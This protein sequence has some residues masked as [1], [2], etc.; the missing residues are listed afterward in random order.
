MKHLLYVCIIIIGIGLINVGCKKG[1]SATDLSEES[2]QT[3]RITLY[4]DGY[5]GNVSLEKTEIGS[6]Y[7]HLPKGLRS[8]VIYILKNRKVIEVEEEK[9]AGIKYDN[10]Y[11]FDE[12][13]SIGMKQLMNNDIDAIIEMNIEGIEVAIE[14]IARKD[15]TIAEEPDISEGALKMNNQQLKILVGCYIDDVYYN[16]RVT[17]VFKDE[18]KWHAMDLG[19]ELEPMSQIINRRLKSI[20]D[21]EKAMFSSN[22]YD[23]IEDN[24][25]YDYLIGLGE[26][27]LDIMLEKLRVSEE[28]GLREYLLAIACSELLGEDIEDKRWS[29]G[30]EWY[31]LYLG[32]ILDDAI[33]SINITQPIESDK[34][35]LVTIELLNLFCNKW[36]RINN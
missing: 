28:N 8:L 34:E 3:T 11:V 16:A 21:N 27:A 36:T 13:K 6:P 2:F 9:G 4:L 7:Y 10:E 25:D 32:N 30:K 14:K 35:R 12:V 29:T 20:M 24:K 17:G 19:T 31:E 22:P 1:E 33:N 23:Y 15:V 5:Y 26:E 18:V